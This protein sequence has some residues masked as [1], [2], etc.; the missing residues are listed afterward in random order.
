MKT[1]SILAALALLLTSGV[2]E[3]RTVAGVKLPDMATVGGK[4]LVLNGAGVRS[5]FF[6]KVYVGALYLPSKSKS[7]S[8][9]IKSAPK[10]LLMHFIYSK[11][12]RDKIVDAWNEG[13]AANT[14]KGEMAALKSRIA[15]FNG[16]FGDISEGQQIVLDYIPDKGTSVKVAGKHKGTIEGDDFH[17][18]LMRIWFG[19]KP[20]TSDLKKGLLGG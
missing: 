3:A 9:A 17:Q 5:K 11:V 12:E 13:F 4:S 19:K 16:M 15:R 18:A 1:R 14:G 7:A 10:R 2:L 6:V 20:V 8:V